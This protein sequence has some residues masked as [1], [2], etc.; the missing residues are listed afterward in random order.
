MGESPDLT[1][2]QRAN[3]T[4]ILRA[5][6]RL[7]K[8]DGVFIVKFQVQTGTLRIKVVW[9]NGTEA[10]EPFNLEHRVRLSDNPW[11][12]KGNRNIIL[13]D[14]PQNQQYLEA[15]RQRGRYGRPMW[16]RRSWSGTASTTRGSTSRPAPG[17]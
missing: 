11:L 5:A 10:F 8:P 6:R 9:A 14:A 4:R 12:A 3:A 16:S 2:Q 15:L 17:K 1:P 7:L 13:T